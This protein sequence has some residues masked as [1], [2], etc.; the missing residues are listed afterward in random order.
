VS[1]PSGCELQPLPTRHVAAGHSDTSRHELAPLH[2]TSQLHA[3]PHFV[4]RSQES[5][6][7]HVT[8]QRCVLQMISSWH[9]PTPRQSTRQSSAPPQFTL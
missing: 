9:E 6:P 5:W 2:V 3:F 8:S 4:R 7:L 1:Q